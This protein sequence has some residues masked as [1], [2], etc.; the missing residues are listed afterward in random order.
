MQLRTDRTE[1]HT[2]QDST[3]DKIARRVVGVGPGQ[4]TLDKSSG[5]DQ[6]GQDY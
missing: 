2:W 6:T 1:Q 3:H 4:D 5:A